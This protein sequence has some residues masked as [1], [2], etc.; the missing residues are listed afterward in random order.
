MKKKIS[1]LLGFLML[2]FL[3]ITQEY[4]WAKVT[5]GAQD[6]EVKSITVD[7]SG[8]VLTTGVFKGTVDFDPGSGVFNLT[9]VG[10]YDVFVQKLDATGNFLWAI[11]V[12]GG[13]LDIGKAIAV[14]ATGNSYIT[15]RFTGTAVDFDPSPGGVFQ[16]TAASQDI[17]ILK[18]DVNGG[19]LWAKKMGGLFADMAR[20]IA[21]DGMSNVY[22][23]GYRLCPK[24]VTIRI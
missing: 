8:N 13:G 16:M 20:S 14:D 2:N 23:T 3:A 5:G 6:D 11:K 22:I 7:G 24:K 1:I 17:Y 18:L 10:N 12:G 21:V 9:A 4:E 15:G 19:F